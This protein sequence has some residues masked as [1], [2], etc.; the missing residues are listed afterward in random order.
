MAATLEIVNVTK[1]PVWIELGDSDG[2][3]VTVIVVAPVDETP[4]PPAL[5]DRVILALNR[6]LEGR[7]SREYLILPGESKGWLAGPYVKF[8]NFA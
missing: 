7:S 2:F 8:A 3:G 6:E 1:R 5:G 4:E